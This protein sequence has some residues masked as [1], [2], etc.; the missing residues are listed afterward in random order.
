M[1]H[2]KLQQGVPARDT[3]RSRVLFPVGILIEACCSVTIPDKMDVDMGGDMDLAYR[4]RVTVQVDQ[5]R[6]NGNRG[7]D[8]LAMDGADVVPRRVTT[9]HVGGESPAEFVAGSEAA[10]PRGV[11]MWAVGHAP[12]G[13]VD[14]GL[15]AGVGAAAGAVVWLA[16][17]RAGAIVG[18]A[19]V[20]AAGHA[21][22]GGVVVE[23]AGAGAGAG[24]DACAGA[25]A[26]AGAGAIEGVGGAGEAGR[27]G[28]EVAHGPCPGC[29]NP[30]PHGMGEHLQTHLPAEARTL[31]CSGTCLLCGTCLAARRCSP[32]RVGDALCSVQGVLPTSL[33]PDSHPV[34]WLQPDQ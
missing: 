32:D 4:A 7:V 34:A 28:A 16:G 25:G 21:A 9:V 12:T 15:G 8:D 31:V 18:A 2:H 22:P 10:E 3:A 27:G 5:G 24:F 17:G 33:P 19:G 29:N 1:D 13:V 26:G 6:D 14:V 30:D 20:P 23:A 11:E